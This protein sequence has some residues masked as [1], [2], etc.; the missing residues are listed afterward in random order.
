MKK[1]GK[2]MMLLIVSMPLLL[3][4]STAENYPK[5]DNPY[6]TAGFIV[7]NLEKFISEYNKSKS[8]NGI[9]G[10][11][12]LASSVERT[13]KGI[14]IDDNSDCIYLD[15][16]DD[17]G[18]VLVGKNYEIL[19]RSISGDLE[20]AKDA[21]CLYWSSYD[22][23]VYLEE[24]DDNEKHYVSYEATFLNND[25][26]KEIAFQGYPGQVKEFSDGS[27]GIEDISPYMEARYGKGWSLSPDE[28]K[29]I[30][31]YQ[32][33]NQDDYAVDLGEGNCTLSAYFG[34]FRYLHDYGG[35]NQLPMETT[36]IYS[37][38]SSNV[39][40]EVPK[41]YACLRENAMEYGYTNYSSA[42]TSRNMDT[43]GRKTLFDFGY[44][45]KWYKTL[46]KMYVLWS[47]GQQV[48][49]NI[50][51]GYP[52]MWNQARGNYNCHSMVCKG[53]K[54]YKKTSGWFIFS[55]TEKKHF[56]VIN[57]N[58][59][60]DRDYYIDF[61]GYSSDLVHEGFGTFVVVRDKA[62]F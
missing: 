20:F 1:K 39:S 17:N 48:V 21:D 23:F 13:A 37:V 35:F 3:G 25:E 60:N 47:F 6:E 38:S 49:K 55:H 9:D 22:G 58:W 31:N 12:W 4:S 56:M 36:T 45:D 44:K 40:K 7:N 61:D 27:D 59:E 29:T 33:V 46:I 28:S 50:N 43:W 53:Y 51:L 8:E 2:E 26:L 19:D 14:N 52:V 54:T 18:Y 62:W 16:N 32:N 30:Y 34:I 11:D 10:P 15:F 41:T 42:W 24:D 57:N 5:K